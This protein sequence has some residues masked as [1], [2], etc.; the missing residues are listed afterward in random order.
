MNTILF[1]WNPKRWA[2]DD[3]SHAVSEANVEGRH[4]DRW[5]CGVTKKIAL[6]DRAFLMRLGMPPKGIMGSGVVVT[7]PE[8]G[9]HWDS[10]RA[11]Q[12]DKVFYVEILFDVLSETPLLGED[13]LSSPMFAEHNW[14]PQASGTFIPN[15]VAKHLV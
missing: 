1:T 11:A 13:V 2:W 5:S 10:E 6:G 7:E 8:E 14:Y 9:S 12:G 3:L 4:I 15:D